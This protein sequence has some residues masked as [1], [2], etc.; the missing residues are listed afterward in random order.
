[1]IRPAARVALVT[2]LT[3]TALTACGRADD[4]GSAGSTDASTLSA[5]EATGELTV[6]AMGAEGEALP[7]F[8][9]EF[10]DANP[11]VDIEVVPI[12][13][14]AARDKFQTA[15]AA[16]T[17]PDLA[18]M[19]S[20]WMAEFGD[21]FAPVPEG[22]DTGDF[23]SGPLSTTELDGTSVGVPWYVDTRVLYYRTDLAEQAGW[24]EPPATQDE[25]KQ[26]A[27]D[28][29]DKAGAD[30]GI[31]LQSAGNDSFQGSLWSAWSNG[32]SLTNDDATEWTLDTPEM[33]ES[34]EYYQ[35]FFTDGVANPAADR[36]AGAQ[37]AEFVAGTTPML[38][39]GPFMMGQLATLGGE[40]FE[41]K[42]ATARIPAGE[43]STSFAGGSNLV[44]FSDSDNPD[45]AW[46]LI[47]WLTRPETQVSW[48]DV[49]GDLPSQQSAWEDPALADDEKLA[50][51]GEQLEDTVA[52]PVTTTWVQVN[53]AAD[54]VL[55]RMT[56]SGEA[57]ADAL[58]DLQQQAESI[59]MG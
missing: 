41:E 11:E 14:D 43:T 58:A 55:E 29:Q 24:T 19:G 35:S 5:G 37:E 7:D 48:Y 18:M 50:V 51:F 20:T 6:W 4:T 8:V 12:P 56:V 16:G 17:T 45:A 26:M 31:R 59:G 38:I 57:P 23:F 15:I 1:M 27:A 47:D 49:T 52:P 32:A 28:L 25:L 21:A 36:T 9:Q 34:Y 40:G 42:Y 54:S 22:I 44:V 30:Y 3:L 53:A 46:K 39:D 10:V 33:V 2:A 13:W